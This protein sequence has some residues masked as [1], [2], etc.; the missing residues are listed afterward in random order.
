MSTTYRQYQEARDAAWRALLRVRSKRLPID[1]EALARDVGM[2]ILPYPEQ[3][4]QPRLWALLNQAGG[5]RC[6][7][8]RIR[9]EWHIFLREQALDDAARRFSVAHELGHLLLEHDTRTLAPG[10]RV[11][12]T[13]PCAGDLLID[14]ASPEDYAADIFAIRLLA[15]A[16]L[17]HEMHIDTPSGIMRFCLLPP[18]AAA[19]RAERI[20]LLNERDAF[21]SHPLERQVRDAYLPFLRQEMSLP[22]QVPSVP[23]AHRPVDLLIAMPNR[24]AGNDPPTEELPPQG[25]R[26]YGLFA[27]AAGIGGIVLFCIFLRK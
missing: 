6:V 14:P 22:G 26:K 19:F 5:G 15:P 25:K 17:L 12:L 20:Q 21:F 10:V 1:V 27:L 24:P 23:P 2:R 18:K 4:E 13:P 3:R 16:C 7:T 8:L 9:G 11:F